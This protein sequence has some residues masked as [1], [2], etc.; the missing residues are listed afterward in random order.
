[1][2]ED[3]VPDRLL[4]PPVSR[5]YLSMVGTVN[6]KKGGGREKKAAFNLSINS[7]YKPFL[8]TLSWDCLSLPKAHF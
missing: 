5:P 2:A 6:S 4:T 3:S 1:M 7:L 8:S